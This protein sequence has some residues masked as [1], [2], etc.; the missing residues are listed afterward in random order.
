[1]VVTKYDHALPTNRIRIVEAGHPTPDENSLEAGKAILEL[2][3][4]A[5][6]KDLV[7]FL[8]SGGASALMEQPR[9][10]ISLDQLRDVTTRLLKSGADITEL[11]TVRA[12]LSRV[13][14]GGIARAAQPATVAVLI[15]SDV[16]GNSLAT[17]GSGPCFPITADSATACKILEH[18]GV[19]ADLLPGIEESKSIPAPPHYIIGDIWTALNAAAESARL[20]GLD[21]TLLTGSLYGEAKG[22]GKLLGSIAR[23]MPATGLN[24]FVA[25][26]ETTVTVHGDGLGGRSQELA[27][28]AALE[29]EGVEGVAILAAGTDGTDGP[30]EAAGGVVDGQTVARM[31]MADIDFEAELARNNSAPMLQTVDAQ[32]VTGATQTNV[33]DLVIGVC[34]Q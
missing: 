11:N 24:C 4:S 13:K 20:H 17:I 30:T 8:L 1:L 7:L 28:Y 18:Y 34:M 6:K 21:P 14:A 2:A 19:A 5:G 29:I 31:R 33:N 25:G 9:E 3:D 22:V 32:I 26:G 15:I 10:G 16:L 12:C 23:D 27:A